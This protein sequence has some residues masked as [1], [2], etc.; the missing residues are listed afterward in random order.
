MWLNGVPYGNTSE[1]PLFCRIWS[2]N[3]GKWTEPESGEEVTGFAIAP[4]GRLSAFTSGGRYRSLTPAFVPA[5]TN[6][7]HIIGNYFF[8]DGT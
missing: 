8:I 6:E 1:A 2:D 5:G 4:S 7:V 3:D